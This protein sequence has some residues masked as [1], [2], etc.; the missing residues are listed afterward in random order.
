MRGNAATLLCV[1]VAFGLGGAEAGHSGK[2]EQTQSQMA[3]IQSELSTNRQALN[4]LRNQKR[5]LLDALGNLDESLSK[6]EQ[7]KARTEDMRAQLE[8]DLKRLGEEKDAGEQQ[9]GALQVRVQNRLKGLYVMGQGRTARLLLD[10]K[11]HSELAMR[12]FMLQQLTQKDLTLFRAHDAALKK[13]RRI[14]RETEDALAAMKATESALQLQVNLLRDVRSE[15]QKAIDKVLHDR[16]LARR[17]AWELNRRYQALAELVES[18]MQEREAQEANAMP[19][20]ALLK[21][22]RGLAWPVKGEIIR[23]F[24]KKKDRQ[25]GATH[26]SKGLHIRAPLGA[27]V[28]TFANGTVVHV[29]WMRGF[30]RIVIL[31]HGE[32]VHSLFA[33]L[34]EATVMAGDQVKKGTPIGRVG[35]TESLDGP[36]LYFELRRRGQPQNPLKLLKAAGS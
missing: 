7:E 15:R 28:K 19:G 6:L 4:D 2:I 26:V 24:G 23:F 1:A 31:N 11:N 20:L 33:H 25:T 32:S 18:L 9:Y 5:S 12:S 21:R 27:S 29:G 36:K 8:A 34:S 22:R 30:G 10:A 13:I 16:R 35:D 3:A 17:R 14:R